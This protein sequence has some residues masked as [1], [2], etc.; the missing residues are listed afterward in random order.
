MFSF[1]MLALCYITLFVIICFFSIKG[2]SIW[3]RISNI[4]IIIIFSFLNFKCGGIGEYAHLTL[5]H[6]RY[7]KKLFNELKAEPPDKIHSDITNLSENFSFPTAES[8][9]Q[10]ETNNLQVKKLFF[11]NH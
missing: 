1:V 8:N 11:P 5:V 10:F 9:N 7:I 2:F 4:L 6:T 3:I